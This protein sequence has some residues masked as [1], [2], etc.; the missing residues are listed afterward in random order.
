MG[1]G[2]EDH[3]PGSGPSQTQSVPDKG[4]LALS[5]IRVNGGG[6]KESESSGGRDTRAVQCSW[7]TMGEWR[8]VEFSFSVVCWNAKVSR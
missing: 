8:D 7:T 2:T 3:A 1:A 6:I 4:K 5:P